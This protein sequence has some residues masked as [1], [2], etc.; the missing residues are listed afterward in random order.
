[1]GFLRTLS[2]SSDVFVFVLDQNTSECLEIQCF[3]EFGMLAIHFQV[4]VALVDA[5]TAN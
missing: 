1:M 2:D 3:R 5:C 4:F